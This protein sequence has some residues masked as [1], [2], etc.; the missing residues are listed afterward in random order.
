MSGLASVVA[1]RV[2]RGETHDL[3]WIIEGLA[4]QLLDVFA[5][6]NV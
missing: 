2:N 4:R 1:M 3:E 6:V 5:P